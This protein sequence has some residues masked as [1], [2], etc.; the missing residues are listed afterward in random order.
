MIATILYNIR[1]LVDGGVKDN[2][3]E[4]KNDEYSFFHEVLVEFN[5]FLQSIIQVFVIDEVSKQKKDIQLNLPKMMDNESRQNAKRRLNLLDL[6]FSFVT[7]KESLG[8]ERATLI[9][10]MAKQNI[11]ETAEDEKRDKSRARLNL[12]VN[13]LVMVVEEQHRIMSDL[14]KQ[15]GID[16][17]ICEGGKDRDSSTV[18]DAPPPPVLDPQM[19]QPDD[20]Y[21]TLLRLVGE[22]IVPSD[23]MSTVQTHLT[24]DFDITSFQQSMTMDSFWINITCYMDRL[25]TM[26]LFLLEELENCEGGFENL[27]L[28]SLSGGSPQH[29]SAPSTSSPSRP[30]DIERWE[31][32]LYDV[33]FHKRIGRGSAGTTY[34]GTYCNQEVAIK[35]ASTSD[36]GL[37]GWQSELAS[38]Q[39]LHHVNIIRFFGA[40][41]NQ[42]PLT[43][44]LVLEYCNGGDLSEALLRSTPPKFFSNVSSGVANALF[45]L[46]KNNFL[47][48]DIKP[49][50]VLISGELQSGSFIVKLTDFGLAVKVQNASVSEKQELTAETGTYRYMSPEVIRHEKYD[51]AADVFSFGLVMWETITRE[52]PFLFKGP[53]EA[54][55]AVAIEGQR[56]PFPDDTPQAVKDLIESCWAEKPG[57]RMDVESIIKCIDELDNNMVVDSWLSHPPG[58]QVYAPTTTPRHPPI[59]INKV[60]KKKTPWLFRKKN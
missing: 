46:H 54:A 49:A 38:L 53:I 58:H 7:L 11:D 40:I 13:D 10:L 30:K 21:S 35:V 47:H 8:M 52:K 19:Q 26:E 18:L 16:I 31:I 29:L 50:N 27:D 33:E 24:L 5:S 1:Q 32:S 15:S 28:L 17:D 56:P 51:Y 6:I 39:K 36:M 57:D 43:Y 23:T 25:H 2:G 45:Y 9:G 59:N 3:E 14:Q 55:A 4:E 34:K 42:S 48:R 41:Y 20:N 37:E 60:Q 22:S 12:I 44:C